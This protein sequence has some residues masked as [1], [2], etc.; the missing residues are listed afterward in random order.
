MLQLVAY[1]EDSDIPDGHDFSGFFWQSRSSLFYCDDLSD[2][3]RYGSGFT[4]CC[5]K[6]VRF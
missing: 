4:S 3:A 2:C 1:A 5:M 6:T